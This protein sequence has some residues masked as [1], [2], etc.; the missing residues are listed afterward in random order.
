M[1]P[2]VLRKLA[3]TARGYELT[4]RYLFNFRPTLNYR[5][6]RH[7][8]SG[9]AEQV[10][11]DLNRQGVAITSAHSLLGENYSCYCELQRSVEE[12]ERRLGGEMAAARSAALEGA[13]KDQKKSF[14]FPLLGERPALRRANHIYVRF[15]LQKPILQIA[16]AY[17][18]MYS[19]LCYFNVWHNFTTPSPASTSQLWHRDR[20]DLH[21]IL[22]VFLYLSD[23][24]E[25]AGPF[26]YAAGTHSKKRLLREP[27]YFLEDGYV[28]RSNDSQMAEVIAPERWVRGVGPKGTIIFADT[29]GYHKGG[30]ARERDR[31]MYTC[32]FSSSLAPEL[33][34]RSPEETLLWMDKEQAYALKAL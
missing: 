13:A 29:R 15:A 34:E 17:F 32:M 20:D 30:L 7:A 27:A 6:S 11:E 2:P 24:D 22:K 10:L 4:F 12:L 33:F 5:L 1:A 28:M 16:N 23:V 19:R 14:I 9:E 21:Y 18:S 25:G 3:R 8:L 26:M 31:I